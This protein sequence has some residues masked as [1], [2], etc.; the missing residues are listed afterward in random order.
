MTD[1]YE[2]VHSALRTLS[3]AEW[4][5]VRGYHELT[6]VCARKLA[7]MFVKI[8]LDGLDMQIWTLEG[9]LRQLPETSWHLWWALKTTQHVGNAG[10]HARTIKS[11]SADGERAMSAAVTLARAYIDRAHAPVARL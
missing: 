2:Y 8:C 9:G 11:S 10:A 6:A 7:E 5:H 4:D 1:G 3:M